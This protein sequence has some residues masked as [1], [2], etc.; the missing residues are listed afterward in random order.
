M[1]NF[2]STIR[3]L[4][5]PVAPKPIYRLI[6]QQLWVTLSESVSPKPIPAAAFDYKDRDP[7]EYS[8]ESTT[9]SYFKELEWGIQ[10]DWYRRDAHWRLGCPMRFLMV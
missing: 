9:D 4:G 8:M 2:K 7:S 6:G 3:R 1:V 5:G 10:P